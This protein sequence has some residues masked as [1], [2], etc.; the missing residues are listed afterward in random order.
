M[1]VSE[2]DIDCNKSELIVEVCFLLIVKIY[3][4][5]IRFIQ[6]I[7]KKYE[8]EIIKNIIYEE[9]AYK[10]EQ[11]EHYFDERFN[12]VNSEEKQIKDLIEEYLSQKG[13]KNNLSLDDIKYILMRILDI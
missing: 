11:I 3:K 7:K 6:S 1:D 9:I 2:F 5:E 12:Y 8:L 13:N 4:K 10:L